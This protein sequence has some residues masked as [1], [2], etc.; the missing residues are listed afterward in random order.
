MIIVSWN[1]KRGR[2]NKSLD[3]KKNEAIMTLNPDILILQEFV[4]CKERDRDLPEKMQLIEAVEFEERKNNMSDPD[5]FGFRNGLA[6]FRCNDQITI[7]VLNQYDYRKDNFLIPMNVISEKE[8]ISFNLLAI[9]NYTPRFDLTIPKYND[10][11]SKDSI[12]I[13]DFNWP[14]DSKYNPC[15]EKLVSRGRNKGAPKS[16]IWLFNFFKGHKMHSAYHGFDQEKVK[17]GAP[18]IQP[19]HYL[20]GKISLHIDYCFIPD[21]WKNRAKLDILSKEWIDN[22]LSDHCPLILKIE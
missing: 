19:T 22:G 10:L 13:G 14:C 17:L 5:K 2:S 4:T 21:S 3:K 12:V 6:V 7:E 18:N 15:S 16:A 20:K 9:W 11:F 8:N 1:R